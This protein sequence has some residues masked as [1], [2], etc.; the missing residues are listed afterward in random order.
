[1]R[2]QI[3]PDGS[4]VNEGM[5]CS[6][7]DITMPNGEPHGGLT[8]SN[9]FIL[10]A[11]GKK[12]SSENRM[13]QVNQWC[14]RK[15]KSA[16]TRKM[17]HK[18]LPISRWLPNVTGSN[19]HSYNSSDAVGD[20]VAG[21]TVG[22]TVIPQALAY[23]G[24]AGLPAA[25]G[26][27]GS[28]LGCI[29]YIFL[30]SCKDV[31]MGPTAI[32]ALLTYQ[33]ARGNV[34]KSILLCLLTGI[35][36]L[37]MGL[38]GL[39]FLVD[40]VSGPVSS[41]F[42]SAVSLIIVTSQIKDVLGISAKGTTFLE[43]W[44]AIFA[45][46]H[47]I[48]AWD[49]VLGLT[50]IAVLLIMRIVAGLKV[51]PEEDTLKSRKHRIINKFMWLIGTSRNAIL[52]VV[53]GAIGYVF[54]SSA[55]AP[56]K[57][58]GEIPPG[59]PS[60]QAPLFS[61]TANETSSGRA[62][63]FSEI[64]SG[65]GSGLI[66]V[67]LIALMENIAICKAFSNG[68][69]VDATQELIAIGV[70]NIA[71]SFVQGFPGTGSLSRSAVNNASGVRT[72]MGNIYT[73]ALV[74]LSLMFFT[75][76]FSYIP[77]ASL[78]AIIIAAVVFMVEVKVVKPMWR[79]KKSD[80]IPGLSTF[81]A[82]LALPLEMGILVGVGLN[83]IFILYHAARPKISVERLTSPGG[84]EYLIITPD[85]CLIFPSVDYVRNLVTKHS[86]RQSLPVVI[87]C[88]HVYGADYTAATVID[89]IT[90]DFTKRDQPLF[91]YN[92]KPSVCAV[93]EGLSPVDFVVYY[94][95]EHLDELLKERAYK[96]KQV[97]S[98]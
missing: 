67:P 9:E 54:Q 42:T 95:E 47:N 28:F 88:S 27:Y 66:V 19:F 91:F 89:S 90:A 34:A 22:L 17:L 56:F 23:S 61:L 26:L 84:T 40:F 15:V 80:L 43:I 70:A 5:N 46:I 68:K 30:G 73:G 36:E 85:R 13:E 74:V 69:P 81:I 32:S 51:G 25:Y 94:R 16:C 86:I 33:T 59:M 64:V 41:G 57:L 55:Q 35:I 71:N 82:C 18:R 44:Q 39:G 37:L 77:K 62:E 72:P 60:F 97:L 49:T 38:F 24:I 96:P 10:S 53:C 21:I 1:M 7:L 12:I 58:I 11:S 3:S 50:C 65:L 79:T 98:A 20:L 8:G 52:V 4:Y 83:V 48:R 2:T 75:P 63:S 14:Q 92:L 87:D 78:A 31:P 93:F 29:V 76:Y 6:S 45:D